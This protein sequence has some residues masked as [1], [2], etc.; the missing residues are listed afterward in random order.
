MTR[1]DAPEVM[2]QI[3]WPLR[4][5]WAGL[6]AERLSRA[7][8]PL[9]TVLLLALSALAFGAQDV[10]PLEA[11]WGGLVAI[12]LGTLWALISGFRRFRRPTRAEALARLDA[13]LPGQPLSALSDDLAIGGNDPAALAVWQAHRARMAA[14]V[15]TARPVRPMLDLAPRDPFGLRFL[16]LTALVMALMFGSIWRV[17]S[18][19]G[20]GANPAEAMMNGPSWEAWA[21]PP[22]HT[23]KPAL[24]LNDQPAGTLELPRGTRVQVRLYG[25]VGALT[26]SETVSAATTPPPASDLAQNFEV[27]QDGAIAINGPGG[28]EWQVVALKD[29]APMISSDGKI[30][31]ERDGKMKLPFAAED[32]FAI[33][34]GTATITLDMAALD[35]RYGLA[36]DPEPRPALVLDLPLPIS[37]NRAKFEDALVEDV[38]EH[39][40]ANM[41]VQV[42]LEVKDAQGQTGTAA[43]FSLILPGKRFFDP[44]AAAIIELR[45]DLLWNRAS[46]AR[47]AQIFKAITH[48]PEDLTRDEKT[49]A[50]LKAAITKLDTEKTALTPE[51]RD[52]LA[53]ELWEI[54][55]LVEEGDLA[56]ARERLARAQERLNEAIRNGADPAEIQ[57]LMEELRA[58]TDDYMRLLAQEMERN[59]DGAEADAGERMEV[60]GD[61]IQ[62]MM[63]EI[64]RLME[65]GKM[66]EAAQA[67]AMLQ[68]LLENL[69][70]T[71]GGSGSGGPQ[72]PGMKGLQ[73]TL[74]DQQSLSDE[75]FRDL[76]QG[77]PD[78]Q[79]DEGESQGGD[80]EQGEQSLAERQEQLRDRLDGLNQ[81]PLPGAGTERGSEG[82]EALDE[83]ERRMQ[84]AERALREGDLSGAL[85]RQAEAMDAMRDGMRALGEAQ[86]EAERREAEGPEGE[87][88]AEREAA[89]DP[90]GREPGENSR[91][92]GSDRNLL[93]GQDVERRAQ[94]LLDEI[95]RRAG[96]QNRSE[97]E[98]DYLKRLLDLF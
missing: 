43:P 65:E 79:P 3:R 80:Q 14:R 5:T 95:R 74:R 42:R 19:T 44:L 63:D 48:L 55:L 4:L 71:E 7:F 98:R 57:E 41:P 81:G 75:A 46:A 67:M 38:S 77:G 12:A 18:V 10:L 36:M 53:K 96:E 97:T 25:E 72:M 22:L 29:R 78:A 58:A 13:S 37:G 11:A 70:M 90:L 88:L 21:Q 34:G 17:A 52:A 1:P 64:Q 59:P 73:E 89:R 8:W 60:T 68:Q 33:A 83:A 35:R 61:Q 85:D 84:E 45:R 31:R 62:E 26:L 91:R 39:A 49:F 69:Q 86:S 15:A 51:A 87:R 56:S 24:Y 6:W 2:R 92:I 50:R 47:A 93:Q 28:R 30:T 9:W 76:Q 20:L 94:D 23:G 66:A 82:R 54:A 27:L 16:A 40:F 32:D